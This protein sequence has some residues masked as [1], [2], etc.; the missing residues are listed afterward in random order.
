MVFWVCNAGVQSFVW[1]L[2]SCLHLIEA[3][4]NGILI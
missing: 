3:C 2:M 1:T 4:A